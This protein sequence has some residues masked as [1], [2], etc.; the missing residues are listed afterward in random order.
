MKFPITL[1]SPVQFTAP[2]PETSDVVIIGGGV[3]G[4]CT[5]LFLAR[6][7]V[8][9]TVIEKGRVACE[10]SSRNW[11]W[12]RQQ[13]RDEAELPIMI[14]SRRRWQDIAAQTKADIGL[15]QGGVTYLA[16]NDKDMQEFADWVKIAQNHG[17]DTVLFDEK[18]CKAAYPG[19]TDTMR[20]AMFT[21]SD[22]RAEPWVAVPEIAKLAV[23]AGATIIENCAARR[24]DIQGGRVT[25]VVTEN[26][27]IRTSEV[28]LCGGAWSGLFAEAHGVSIPQ[29]AVRSSV[30]ATNVLPQVVQGG[31]TD[32]AIAYRPRKDG[33]YSLAA[34]GAHEFFV[35]PATLKHG[36]KYLRQFM[37]NPLG[38]AFKPAA[39]RDYPDAWST[40]RK[41]SGDDQ[42]PF[43][44]MRILNPTPNMRKLRG[45]AEKFAQRYPELGKV[46]I[47]ASW[48]GMIDAMPDVV[49]ILDRVP[50]VQ[51]L[52]IGT[53]LSG[54]GFGIGP[55]I[56]RVLADLIMGNEVGHDLHRFRFGRFT[57]GSPMVPGPAL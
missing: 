26:G 48:A 4:I 13:G 55:G 47:R 36:R 52:T 51:G 40:A 9:V 29:L 14:E 45:A 23:E 57:D 53:G 10:Q 7:N 11:G 20:G 44:R 5:A 12:I 19:M 22:M 43:E 42:S 32:E 15:T 25:G 27:T 30:A 24:L 54:H 3:V 17:V 2:L 8:S 21:A 49:P 33:G 38:T 6:K 37:S 50:N 16:R 1:E 28:L 46:E 39:P 35:G 56:G 41:W 31:V 18:D 34:G